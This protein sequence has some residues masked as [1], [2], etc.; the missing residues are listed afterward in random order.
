MCE[1]GD[2]LISVRAPV[3]A[4]NRANRA[5]CIGRGLAA[6]RFVRASPEFGWHLLSY[7][8]KDLRRVAQG[9]TFKAISRDNLLDLALVS[10]DLPEQRRIAE[11]LDAADEAI[12]ATERLIEEL[13]AIK[14]GLL[15]DL[16]TRGVDEQG[17]L[18]DPVAHPEQFVDSPLGRLPKKWRVKP[19]ETAASINPESLGTHTRADT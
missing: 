4:L 2:I 6:V 9:S 3:G 19:L 5:Y 1:Q 14:Q 13:R 10:F 18:R 16:L 11:I 17:R 12:Q 7:W 8:A 15:H